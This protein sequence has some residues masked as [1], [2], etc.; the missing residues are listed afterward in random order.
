LPSHNGSAFARLAAASGIEVIRTPIR[1]PRANAVCE[2]C[3]GSVRREC[4]DHLLI[5]GE[6]HLGRTLAEYVR[7]FNGARPHQGIAP[8]TPLSANAVASLGRRAP[9]R[10]FVVPV[11]GGLR[12]EYRLAAYPARM[13]QG[14]AQPGPM[15]EARVLTARLLADQHRAAAY[16][17]SLAPVSRRTMR[18]ALNGIAYILN[19]DRL[20]PA[21]LDWACLRYQQTAAVRAGLLEVYAPATVNKMLAALRGVLVAIRCSALLRK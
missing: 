4:V 12:H 18:G 16:L 13:A 7:H 9:P 3:L 2:R 8:R 6:R 10:V 15:G 14:P 21:A 11:L 1:T 17:A 5:L 19:R 20:D